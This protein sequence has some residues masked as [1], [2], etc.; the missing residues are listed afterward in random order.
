[1]KQ[2]YFIVVTIL[3]ITIGIFMNFGCSIPIDQ[4]SNNE[5]EPVNMNTN[6]SIVINSWNAANDFDHHTNFYN[7]WCYGC[8]EQDNTKFRTFGGIQYYN[9]LYYYGS[10]YADGMPLIYKKDDSLVFHPS[11]TKAAGLKWK[12]PHSGY[13]IIHLSTTQGDYGLMKFYLYENGKE[14]IHYLIQ[15]TTTFIPVTRY[16]TEGTFITIA[17]GAGF[18]GYYGGTT[19]ITFNVDEVDGYY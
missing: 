5:K 6:K 15:G 8:L 2:K 10:Y 13:Y 16:I 12:V 18:D 3:M 9:N 19:Y 17:V 7:N 11:P 4:T 1:M 14:V